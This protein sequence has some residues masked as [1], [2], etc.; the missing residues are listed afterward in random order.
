MSFAAFA[1]LDPAV[2]AVGVY[3]PAVRAMLT[4][5]TGPIDFGIGRERWWWEEAH[6]DKGL[7]WLHLV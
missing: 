3:G 1:A 4:L 5:A 6:G 7:D 2:G